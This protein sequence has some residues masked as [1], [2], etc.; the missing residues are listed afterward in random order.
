MN[1]SFNYNISYGGGIGP[2]VW[3]A[4]I[5][6]GAVDIED[7]IKQAKGC[8]EE[9]GGWVFMVS[10]EDYPLSTREKLQENINSL[11]RTVATLTAERDELKKK[12]LTTQ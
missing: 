12:I 8:I 10:Q 4:E 11:A 5:Q 1:Q 3:D 6:I 2:D 9:A 7:A